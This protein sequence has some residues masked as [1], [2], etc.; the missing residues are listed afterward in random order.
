MPKGTDVFE[1]V[2]GLQRNLNKLSTSFALTSRESN[3][4][5]VSCKLEK[6]TRLLMCD[7]KNEWHFK[8][9]V[10]PGMGKKPFDWGE[11]TMQDMM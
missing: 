9:T 4:F 10:L 5:D 11:K 6:M 8:W 3:A 7:M 1:C 2:W